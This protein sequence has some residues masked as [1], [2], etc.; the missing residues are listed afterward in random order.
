MI[1]FGCAECKFIKILRDG[2]PRVREIIGIDYDL[3]LLEYCKRFIEPLYINYLEPRTQTP[4]DLLLMHGD[5]AAFDK[6]LAEVDAVT[7]IEL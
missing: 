5:V 7:A 1:D 2:L 4:L 6:R 3:E